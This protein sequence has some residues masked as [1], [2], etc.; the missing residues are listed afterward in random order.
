MQSNSKS[1]LFYKRINRNNMNYI[2]FING[3]IFSKHISLIF[4]LYYISPITRKDDQVICLKPVSKSSD[5]ILE[6]IILFTEL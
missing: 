5:I 4:F 2:S 6:F 3:T 1:L